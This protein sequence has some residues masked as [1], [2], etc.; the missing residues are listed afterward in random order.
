MPEVRTAILSVYDKTGIVD[1][2]RKLAKLGVRILSTGGTAKALRNESIPI[3]EVSEYTGFPEM[4]DGRV[5]TLHPKIHGGILARRDNPAD[6]EA[7]KSHGIDLIGMVVI[8]LY[9]FEATVA[10]PNVPLAEALENIDIGG[11]SMIRAAAKNY[12][13]V[14]VV[15]SPADYEAVL[16]ELESNRLTLSVETS[17]RLALKAFRLTSHYDAA[18]SAHLASR[19][20]EEPI[21][22]LTLE[23]DLLSPL[24][25]G[26]NPHQKAHL[27]RLA[28]SKGWAVECK[29]LA[30]KELSFNNYLDIDAAYTLAFE[31]EEPA[32]IVIKHNNPC[33]AAVARTLAEAYEKAYSGDTISAFGGVLGFNKPIDVPTAKLISVPGRFYECIIAP[34]YEAEALSIL[35]AWRDDVRLLE[36]PVRSFSPVDYRFVGGALLVQDRDLK[37]LDENKLRVVTRRAPTAAEMRE[38]RFAWLVAK[39]VKSNAIV[40]VKD[41]AVVGVGAGQM[42]RVDSAKLAAMKAGDRARGA[43]CGSDAFF[44]FP[45]G[46]E[47][48]ADAGVTAIIQPGGSKKDTEVIAVADRHNLAMVFTGIRH[49]KH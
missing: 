4:M 26:E 19:Q 36:G 17:A 31:F 15:T 12:P 21:R 46:V 25:Y 13:H 33:G 11:P 18:I 8:N 2:A 39:A 41:R 9:P 47:V 49:F 1:F 5:K 6:L 34:G 32:A 48:A 10:K 16:K 30:G 44:P 29:V 35:K 20:S 28:G 14:A 3:T 27:Y 24:R 42:S 38:L 37:D 45:D 23:A 40:Y 22:R 7:A 43:V